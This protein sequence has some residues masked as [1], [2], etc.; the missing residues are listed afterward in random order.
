M[1][2]RCTIDTIDEKKQWL[3][4]MDKSFLVLKLMQSLS[5]VVSCSAMCLSVLYICESFNLLRISNNNYFFIPK[6]NLKMN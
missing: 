5:C 3:S 1:F 4:L 6:V 2:F